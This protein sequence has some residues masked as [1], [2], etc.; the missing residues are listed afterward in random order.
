MIWSLEGTATVLAQISI[1]LF[2]RSQIECMKHLAER[3]WRGK[4][5]DTSSSWTNR[6]LD[7]WR[8][9]RERCPVGRWDS[10]L[11]LG[12]TFITYQRLKWLKRLNTYYDD[13]RRIEIISMCGWHGYVFSIPSHLQEM[14]HAAPR[15]FI[16]GK[17]SSS[18]EPADKDKA[19]QWG[20]E[21]GSLWQS[22]WQKRRVAASSMLGQAA[23]VSFDV[24]FLTLIDWLIGMWFRDLITLTNSNSIDI[25]TIVLQHL[26][27][28]SWKNR[29][30]LLFGSFWTIFYTSNSGKWLQ[31]STLFTFCCHE[32]I[33]WKFQASEASCWVLGF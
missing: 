13:L 5:R 14:C 4:L 11:L 17:A 20:Q 8:T 7:T 6:W 25:M 30:K 23:C 1:I 32:E 18:D 3:S 9:C 27:K 2:R 31:L 24:L 22:N 21:C 15:S 16:S 26:L 10:A 28:H 12:R 29:R 33:P 19:P